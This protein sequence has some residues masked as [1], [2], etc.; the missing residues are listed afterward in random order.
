MPVLAIGGE[1]ANRAL[2]GQHA[3]LGQQRKLVAENATVVLLLLRRFHVPEGAPEQPV[4]DDF[5][6]AP[7]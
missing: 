5:E 7:Q 2:L 1:K 6:P 4:I 3:L